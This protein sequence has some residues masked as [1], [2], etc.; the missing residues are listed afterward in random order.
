MLSHFNRLYGFAD[1]CTKRK[2]NLV[3]KNS[4]ASVSVGQEKPFDF[5]RTLFGNYHIS[6]L[7]SYRK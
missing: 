3:L 5:L 4:F 6:P 7:L 2:Q 1:A